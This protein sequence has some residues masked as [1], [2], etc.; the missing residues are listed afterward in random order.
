MRYLFGFLCVCALG[1]MPLVGCSE[2]TGDGG[3]GGTAGTGGLAG[4]G[5]TGGVPQ[6]QSPEDCDDDNECTDDTCL[7]GVCEFMPVPDPTGPEEP[8]DPPGEGTTCGYYEGTCEGGS[9]VGTFACTE[10]GIREAIAAGAGPHTF[11]CNGATTV[12]TQAPIEI[13]NDVI[14]DG[15]G[16][17]TVD[18]NFD[19]HVFSVPVGVTAELQGF[20]VTNGVDDPNISGA[21]GIRID[22]DA[23]VTL[24]D[25]TVSGN[26]GGWA[27][28][29]TNNR[30][31]LTLSSSTVS[32]NTGSGIVS[33]GPLT[34]T[35]S[36]VSGN[37]SSNGASGGGIVAYDITLLVNSTISGNSSSGGPGGA[38]NTCKPMAGGCSPLRLISSTIAGNIGEPSILTGDASMSVTNSLVDGDCSGDVT[39]N[40]YNIES[41]G[42]TCRFD[43]NQ[44]DQVNVSTDD[45]NLGPLQDNGGPTMTHAL[46]TEPIVSV[47]VDVIPADDCVDAEGELLP[48]DQRGKPRFVGPPFGPSEPVGAG[49]DVGAFEVQ[50]EP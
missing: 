23:T 50:P 33:T 17:V 49:C 3:G 27:G 2:T 30:G 48:T 38:I 44:G 7:A 35:D 8:G 46:L 39:S 32:D 47:A 5:G 43:T 41:P 6:C 20:T 34:L 15:A 11:A 19:H 4:S 40:G 12:V 28:G 31:T 42:N 24:T 29:I 9:C 25:T 45:L 21:G 14:L 26:T 37:V 13:D 16:E 18:G 10:A 36:T 22:T 1:I